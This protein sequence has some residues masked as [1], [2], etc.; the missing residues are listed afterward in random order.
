MGL[1]D[2][3]KRKLQE[4]SIDVDDMNSYEYFKYKIIQGLKKIGLK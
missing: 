1:S 4:E 3:I 2:V